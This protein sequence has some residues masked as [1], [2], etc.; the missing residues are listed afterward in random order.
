MFTQVDIEMSFIDRED[1]YALIEGLLKRIWKVALDIDVPTPFKRLSFKEALDRFCIDKPDTRFAMEIQDFTEEF[2]NT[3][4]LD[5]PSGATHNAWMP[6]IIAD[7]LALTLLGIEIAIGGLRTP[8]AFRTD[9]DLLR[10]EPGTNQRIPDRLRARGRQLIVVLLLA[11]GIGM[12]QFCA[13]RN[14][15]SCQT[16]TERSASPAWGAY[17]QPP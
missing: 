5:F 11:S 4:G 13:D 7:P 3:W 2:R 16:V 17:R 12:P 14:A 6:P 8:L 10:L 15:R 9:D 1:I